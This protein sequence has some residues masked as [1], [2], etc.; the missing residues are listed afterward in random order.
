MR[1]ITTSVTEVTHFSSYRFWL[2]LDDTELSSKV[3]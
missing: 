1:G 3:N 2:L